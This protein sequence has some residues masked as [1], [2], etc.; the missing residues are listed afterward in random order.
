[1]SI[2]RMLVQVLLLAACGATSFVS[3][4]MYMQ[5]KEQIR[6]EARAIQ[7]PPVVKLLDNGDPAKP[8]SPIIP[9]A[10][11][12]VSALAMPVKKTAALVPVKPAQKVATLH[13]TKLA[14]VAVASIKKPPMQLAAFNQVE[15]RQAY[16]YASEPPPLRAAGI[17]EI[18]R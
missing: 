4:Q 15:Q 14:K 11:Y 6:S 1:M 2:I 13:A 3:A 8:L 9:T 5:A 18:F 16:G 12:A 7:S 17:F 10:K